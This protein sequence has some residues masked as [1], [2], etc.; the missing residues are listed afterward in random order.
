MVDPVDSVFPCF[1]QAIFSGNRFPQAPYPFE[2]PKRLPWSLPPWRHQ[3][4]QQSWLVRAA[5]LL[6]KVTLTSLYFEIDILKLICTKWSNYL[7]KEFLPLK[8]VKT[9]S[10]Y[11]FNSPVT[12]T[13]CNHTCGTVK[14]MKITQGTTVETWEGS[15]IANLPFLGPTLSPLLPGILGQMWGLGKIWW[16]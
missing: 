8:L 7:A 13:R 1:R 11:V 12:F 3:G 5:A 9:N 2:V 6:V 16:H 14:I 15:L 4:S 10:N